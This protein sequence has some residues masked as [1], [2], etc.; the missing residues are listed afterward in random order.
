MVC[1]FGFFKKNWEIHF[2]YVVILG[3]LYFNDMITKLWMT[4]ITSENFYLKEFKD[5]VWTYTVSSYSSSFGWA[6]LCLTKSCYI[7]LLPS[8]NVKC[9]QSSIFMISLFVVIGY[10]F[11]SW[12][13]MVLNHWLIW[14]INGLLVIVVC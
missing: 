1:N 9:C 6:W 2:K 7:S 5:F 11:W 3:F 10:P 4:V 12:S 14:I 13:I 8:L